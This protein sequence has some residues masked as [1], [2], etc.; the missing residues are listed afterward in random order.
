ME[1]DIGNKLWDLKLYM[2]FCL[3]F[4]GCFSFVT[5][6]KFVTTISVSLLIVSCASTSRVHFTKGEDDGSKIAR[7]VISPGLV[8][9][10]IDSED[11]PNKTHF[12]NGGSTGM[13]KI[14]NLLPGKHKLDLGFVSYRIKSIAT[15]P[16]IFE[17]KA[18]DIVFLCYDTDEKTKTWKP[19]VYFS[20]AEKVTTEEVM[21]LY[22]LYLTERE[23]RKKCV[24]TSN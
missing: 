24:A 20:T 19:R 10:S 7:I 22:N 11:P 21:G 2:I 17:A 13:N 9:A 6:I 12:S 18:G 23:D 15:L 3:T 16:L 1:P 5:M 4:N 8:V 14:F